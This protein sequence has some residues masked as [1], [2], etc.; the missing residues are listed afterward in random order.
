MEEHSKLYLD[1]YHHLVNLL[2]CLVLAKIQHEHNPT[3]S[4]RCAICLWCAP[5]NLVHPIEPSPWSSCKTCNTSYLFLKIFLLH[6]V[7]FVTT[8]SWGPRTF[9][10]NVSQVFSKCLPNPWFKNTHGQMP[11]KSKKVDKASFDHCTT[12]IS[13]LVHWDRL[14]EAMI[15]AFVGN[16]SSV[17]WAPRE[18]EWRRRPM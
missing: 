3:K 1:L 11:Y 14:G 8:L 7:P 5:Q 10:K 2:Q 13:L 4:I 15:D 17:A 18:G 12:L 6:L 16:A 9:C